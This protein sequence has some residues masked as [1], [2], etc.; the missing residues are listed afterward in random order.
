MTQKTTAIFGIAVLA[1]ILLGGLTFSQSAFAGQSGG[2]PPG[3]VTICH[4]DVD[5]G[6]DPVTISVSVKA[7][8]A[9]LGRGCT[10][11]EYDDERE[12]SGGNGNVDPG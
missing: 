1:A 6:G 4:V 10:L 2:G 3:K 11:G 12:P 5:D 8:P 7:L 9:H